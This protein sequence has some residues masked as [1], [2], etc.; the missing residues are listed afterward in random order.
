M[1]TYSEL[2]RELD[3]LYDDDNIYYQVITTALEAADRIGLPHRLKLILAQPRNEIM[4]QFPVRMDNGQY[5]LFKGYRVQHNNV[6]GPYKG[7]IRYHPDV[8]LDHVKALAALMTMKSALARI[9]FGGAKGAVKVDPRELSPDELMR[10]TRRF[11]HA[12]GAN[13][14]PV[15]DIPAP[16]VGTNAQI[17]AWMADTYVNLNEPQKRLDGQGVVTGKPLDF[18][19][20]PGREKA[21][22]QGVV[23]VLEELLPQLGFDIE[24]LSF[25][26]IGYGNV[27][28][29]TGRILTGLGA[30][31]I[32]VLDHT[33]GIR[34]EE[35]IDAEGLARHVAKTGG[36]AGFSDVD[37]VDADAFYATPVDVFIPAALEQMVDETRA[38]QLQCKVVAEAANA[39]L[40]PEAERRL[41]ARDVVVLP[42]ILCNAGGVAVSYLEWKQNRQA[43]TWDLHEVDTRLKSTMVRSAHRVLETERRYGCGMRLA[44]YIAALEY[45]GHVYDLRGIFP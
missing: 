8:Q 23:Y 29:W 13:I 14:G 33:G 24:G 32:T 27:G 36:V 22:G 21:T 19:G 28:S 44:A 30:R 39:P 3:L 26:L 5:R 15:Y 31:L 2:F 43:E 34:R 12:L 9:P 42:A 35:G 16:D 20:S 10:M 38:D 45:I 17:M 41:L 40:T 4:V 1:N 37:V 25:S 18:G 11:T 6:V 7:G